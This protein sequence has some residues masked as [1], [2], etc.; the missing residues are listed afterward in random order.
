MGINYPLAMT[1]LGTS[2]FRESALN[3]RLS[4]VRS[5]PRSTVNLS[6]QFG[7]LAKISRRSE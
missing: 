2:A 1:F 4:L 5:L 7:T 3:N 6:K